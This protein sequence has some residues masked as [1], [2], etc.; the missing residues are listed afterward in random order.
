M[1]KIII[2][3]ILFNITSTYCMETK[4][5][6]RAT[7][8]QS[9]S[10]STHEATPALP[11]PDTRI[12]IGRPIV[13]T[14]IIESNDETQPLIAY[15][16]V[17]LQQIMRERIQTS[18][19]APCTNNADCKLFG[20]LCCMSFISCILYSIHLKECIIDPNCLELPE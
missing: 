16:L 19:R 12:Q 14:L 17:P 3:L 4:K 13:P 15:R 9:L 2:T 10:A 11:A 1:K 7:H 6:T 18:R 20:C 8:L 5:P